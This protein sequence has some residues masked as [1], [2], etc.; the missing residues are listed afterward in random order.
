VALW[1]TACLAFTWLC[2]ESACAPAFGSGELLLNL[3]MV[4]SIASFGVLLSE[5]LA[6]KLKETLWA[7]GLVALFLVGYYFQAF[8]YALAFSPSE[9]NPELRWV[10]SRT[11]L[12][13]LG[14]TTVAFATL[15]LTARTLLSYD[16]RDRRELDSTLF[17]AAIDRR[18][19]C[20]SCVAVA[21]MCA[22]ASVL[23]VCLKLQLGLSSLGEV[24]TH[25]PLHADTLINRG[26]DDLAPAI[27][28]TMAWVC[29]EMGATR[30]MRYVLILL[31]A[32][33][34][35]SAVVSTSRGLIL[36]SGLSIWI[37]WLVT[38][39]MNLARTAC[40]ATVLVVGLHAVPMLSSLR[41]NKLAS[42]G[43]PAFLESLQETYIEGGGGDVLG[44]LT[45]PLL[46]ISGSDGLWRTLRFL[47]VGDI[48]SVELWRAF[49]QRG[50]VFFF[51]EDIAGVKTPGDYR[52]PGLIALLLM[53]GGPYWLAPFMAFYTFGCWRAWKLSSRILISPV[54]RTLVLLRMFV[55]TMEGTL[56]YQSLI[57]TAISLFI[58]LRLTR[59][60]LGVNGRVS[61]IKSRYLKS[62]MPHESQHLLSSPYPGRYSQTNH[63][64]VSAKSDPA[65]PGWR[66]SSDVQRLF[67]S[68]AS[69]TLSFRK[70]GHRSP[71]ATE[72]ISRLY[73]GT[74][75]NGFEWTEQSTGYNQALICVLEYPPAPRGI[76]EQ[77]ISLPLLRQGPSGSPQLSRQASLSQLHTIADVV[78]RHLKVPTRR[79][80][81]FCAAGIERSPLAVAWYLQ[82]HCGLTLDEAYSLIRRKRPIVRDRRA[83]LCS[84]S[85]LLEKAAIIKVL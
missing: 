50:F 1:L 53:I 69:P 48:S 33:Q 85:L 23:L 11:I 76:P 28:I 64:P 30:T 5:L 78:D 10:D 17:F 37:L 59:S 34:C 77:A 7:W 26:L 21:K 3:Q 12:E 14:Y 43:T 31:L 16:R 44:Q 39:R 8:Y 65:R 55:F 61:A 62:L 51:S 18:R 70:N 19:V 57:A 49:T 45:F 75:E 84:G 63:A 54:A 29:D 46:R 66:I 20:E 27:L 83:W 79:V 81:V 25:L 35:A 56:Y 47:D 68:R 38:R 15:C 40:V 74:V 32:V 4:V 52:S 9:I 41:M 13:G 6:G 67:A 24:A 36:T 82:E 22:G 72:V 73:V 80:L 2:L 60:V 42:N 71:P 58:C